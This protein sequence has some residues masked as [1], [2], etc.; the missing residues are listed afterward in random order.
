MLNFYTF[1][2]ETG[3]NVSGLHFA[4]YRKKMKPMHPI[5]YCITTVSHYAGQGGQLPGVAAAANPS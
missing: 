3:E 1:S 2:S 4:S 5:H